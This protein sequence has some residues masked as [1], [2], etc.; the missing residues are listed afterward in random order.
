MNKTK[1]I[2]GQVLIVVM[3]V[4]GLYAIVRVAIDPSWY[5]G[6][7]IVGEDVA[8]EDFWTAL[9]EGKR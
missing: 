3:M 9:L 2:I 5:F 8:Q 1:M 6:K 4:I 7:S